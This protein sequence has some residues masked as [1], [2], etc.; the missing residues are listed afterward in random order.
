[1]TPKNLRQHIARLDAPTPLSVAFERE[2]AVIFPTLRNPWWSSQQEHWLGWLDEYNGPGF[3]GRSDWNVTAKTVYNRAG[4]PAMVLWLSE[5][6]G[7]P[8]SRVQHA[9]EASKSAGSSWRAKC[10]AIRRVMPWDDVE[11][12]LLGH[13]VDR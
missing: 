4:N 7:L 12:H 10:R 6:A 8:Q 11:R 5:A 2:L 3:Y 1:M 13:S 9:I